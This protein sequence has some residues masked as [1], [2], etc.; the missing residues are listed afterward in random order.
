MISQ[1]I[2]KPGEIIEDKKWFLFDFESGNL[3]ELL[4]RLESNEVN[5]KEVSTNSYRYIL[6]NNS[7]ENYLSKEINDLNKL[8]GKK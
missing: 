2:F 8:L 1:V 3:I 5:L 4:E 6:K 7:F